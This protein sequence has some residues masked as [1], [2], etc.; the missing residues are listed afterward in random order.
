MTPDVCIR[1]CARSAKKAGVA[2]RP[3]S[4]CQGSKKE[5]RMIPLGI[6]SVPKTRTVSY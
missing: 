4:S 6:F 3:A 5:E 1:R 2:A